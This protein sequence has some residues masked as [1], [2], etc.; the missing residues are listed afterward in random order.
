MTVSQQPQ[1]SSCQISTD[2]ASEEKAQFIRE[3]HLEIG[4]LSQSPSSNSFFNAVFPTEAGSHRIRIISSS[5]RLK[6]FSERSFFHESIFSG[7]VDLH[8]I[9]S[10]AF[11]FSG[12][13]SKF[14][15]QPT[16]PKS[17]NRS[18]ISVHISRQ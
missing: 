3:S 1:K 18:S 2:I 12:K 14:P 11:E 16:S 7:I 13:K 17:F 6:L 8:T 4:Q 15:L 9:E 5:H 10:K